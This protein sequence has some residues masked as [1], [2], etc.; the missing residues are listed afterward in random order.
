MVPHSYPL[1][2]N[3]KINA[4][5]LSKEQK[6]EAKKRIKALEKRDNDKLKTDEAKN[7]FESLIYAFKDFLQ[8]DENAKYETRERIEE[9]VQKVSDAQDWLDDAGNEVGY[10]EYQTKSY[11]LQSEFSKLKVRKQEHL[12]RE[13]NVPLVFDRLRQMKDEIP[14]IQEKKPWLSQDEMKDLGEKID[15]LYNWLDEKVAEQNEAGLAVEPI[16]TV[17]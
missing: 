11:D 17:D 7:D 15:D 2:P 14:Q 12:F 1:L 3:E 13:E 9:L 10:K 6:T 8:E 16:F 4:K 5:L